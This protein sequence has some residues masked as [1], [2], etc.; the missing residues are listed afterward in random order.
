ML[1]PKTSAPLSSRSPSMT[2]SSSY[3]QAFHAGTAP[4]MGVPPL[5]LTVG[6]GLLWQQQNNHADKVRHRVAGLG[7]AR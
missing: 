4:T 7:Q 6:L 3:L 1:N 5:E 2:T